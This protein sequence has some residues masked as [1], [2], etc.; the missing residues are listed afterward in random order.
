[1]PTNIVY[2]TSDG[3]ITSLQRINTL[4]KQ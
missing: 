1:M 4:K 3:V 2:L